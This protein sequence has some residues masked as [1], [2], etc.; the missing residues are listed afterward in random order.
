M[1]TLQAENQVQSELELRK[2]GGVLG[3]KDE[4]GL[5]TALAL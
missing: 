1:L 3:G 2:F 5:P 4:E